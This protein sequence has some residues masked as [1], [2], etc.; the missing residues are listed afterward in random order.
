VKLL[1]DRSVAALL[2]AEFVSSL[3]TQITWLAL[4]WFVLT[5]TG[6]PQKMTWVI[7]AELLPMA[8]VGF[9]GGVL[10]QRVGTRRTMLVCDIAR[11]PLVAA[12]PLLYDLGH[13][14]F[15]ALLALV[16]ATGVFVAPYFAVR[17]AIV[18]ELV[19]EDQTAVA[20]ATAVFQAVQRATIFLGPTAAGI[21]I[22]TIGSAH[23]LYVDAATYL[24]SFVLVGL[25]VHLRA[26]VEADAGAGVTGALAG[27][28]FVVRDRLLRVWMTSFLIVEIGW[29]SL[30]ATMPVLVVRHYG[31]DPKVLGWIVGALGAGALVGAGVAY[32]IVARYDPLTLS[33]TAF[34]CQM[35]ALW[36]LAI[37]GPWQLPL[38]A[39]LIGGFFVSIVNSPTIALLT[40][41]T[42]RAL[43]T[44]VMSVFGT[45]LGVAAPLGLV[46]VGFALARVDPRAV[47]VVVLAVQTVGISLFVGGALTERASLRAAAAVD[48]AA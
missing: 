35:G 24:A 32:K 14:P 22:A 37:P 9:F 41:R 46:V 44:Q 45:L 30:F 5:T 2:A 29:T 39:L 17:G 3:G 21:L 7:I 16:A 1:R 27:L 12:I 4:P 31:A 6:S 43:R 19:G 38:L 34:A 23:L 8:A 48:S 42:P 40:L 28:R 18:P 36:L 15:W 47:L 25:F 13:L 11:V 20:Q 10:A 26:T 33:A